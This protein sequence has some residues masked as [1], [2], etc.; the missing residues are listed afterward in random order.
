MV[1]KAYLFSQNAHQNQKRYSG[2][3]YL[4][5]PLEVA[6]ILA[7]LNMDVITIVAGLLHDVVEDTN[8]NLEEIKDAFG[9]EV[10]ML[11]NGVTKLSKISYQT[12]EERQAE[13]FRKMF[14][15]IAE[16]IRVIL[17]KL[18][19]RLNNM[20]TLKYMPAP[21]RLKKAKETLDIYVPIANRLGLYRVKWEL[22]D[23]SLLNLEPKK[24]SELARKVAKSRAEREKYIEFIKNK[25]A[26]ELQKFGIQA[27][28]QGRPKNIYSIYKKMEEQD[29]D[30]FQIYDL[31]AIRIITNSIADCYAALGLLHSIWKP[32]PGRFKDYIAMPKSNMYQSLHTTVVTSE[33]E[34]LEVQ[35][36]TVEMHRTSEYGIAAHWKYK[37]KADFLKDKKFEER[38]TWLRQILE[39]QKELKDPLEFMENLKIDLLQYEVYTFTPKGDVKVLTLGATPVD[40]AYAI[41]TEIGHRCV[42]AKV[43]NRIVPLDRKLKSGDIVEIITSKTSIGPSRDWLKFVKTSGARTRIKAWFKKE[44]RKENIE[45]G[46]N[47]LLRELEK[48]KLPWNAELEEKLNDICQPMGYTD[49]ESLLESIGYKKINPS[50]IMSKVLPQEE[51]QQVQIKEEIKKNQR[52]DQGVKIDGVD[53]IMIRFA[54]CCHP[55]PGDEIVGYVTRGRGVTIHRVECPNLKNIAGEE[56]RLINAEWDK[57]E[58]NYFPVKIKIVSADRKNLI[59]D[60]S[61]ILS[62]YKAIIQHIDGTANRNSIA[63]IHL[64]IEVSTVDHLQ[65]IM[66]RLR[67]LKAVKE[68]TRIE[69]D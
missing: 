32:M 65:E 13:S 62:N 46:K 48:Y 28:I 4:S 20:R 1:L 5:H 68:V 26:E 18:A 33:G 64:T 53:N 2:Q 17:I 67:S 34:P 41:H 51:K 39:W 69:G 49:L 14:L 22:E 24:Y 42:G 3:P 23:Y 37:E 21:K 59:S 11:V 55:I 61:M 8:L 66:A 31:M 15:A 56:G 19:D 7:D 38:L 50:Q 12:K 25:M 52:I 6:D 43:N 16:D 47:L 58:N 40:F 57:T 36:R 29:K 63:V 60:V 45:K 44:L 54:K 35:I 9:E 27:S 30:F 10:A